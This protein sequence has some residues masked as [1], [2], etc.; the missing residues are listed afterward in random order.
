MFACSFCTCIIADQS[1]IGCG[2][3]TLWV[4]LGQIMEVLLHQ[5]SWS[6][7]F[8]T[9]FFSLILIPAGHQEK[10]A[11]STLKS[12]IPQRSGVM[13]DFPFIKVSVESSI[14]HM[15]IISSP[16]NGQT[17]EWLFSQF[18]EQAPSSFLLQQKC[19][20]EYFLSCIVKF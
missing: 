16:G 4:A 3:C 8:K 5:F 6:L 1:G 14:Q 2:Q 12:T 18:M 17:G 15:V 10:A 19:G 9:R 7:F 11:V 13:F 20:F